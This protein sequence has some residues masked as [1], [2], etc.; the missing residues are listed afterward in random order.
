MSYAYVTLKCV[1]NWQHG[2]NLIYR[3]DHWVKILCCCGHGYLPHKMRMCFHYAEI[4]RITRRLIE[5]GGW[6]GSGYKYIIR[7]LLYAMS[8]ILHVT[9]A[10]SLYCRSTVILAQGGYWCDTC[11]SNLRLLLRFGL[12][13]K[14]KMDYFQIDRLCDLGLI[15]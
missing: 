1:S 3:W 8:L 9:R 11:P 15:P 13:S 14:F 10:G 12:K 7:L 4:I 6:Y 5:V 2:Y